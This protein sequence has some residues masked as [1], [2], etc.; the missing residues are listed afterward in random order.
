MAAETR[1]FVS[2]FCVGLF[3]FFFSII[4][5]QVDKT[6]DNKEKLSDKKKMK[7]INAGLIEIKENQYEG[8]PLF[9]NQVH[10]EYDNAILKAD[11]AI[12]YQKKNYFIAKSNTYFSVSDTLQ[13]NARTIEYFGDNKLAK[14]SGNVNLTTK[15]GSLQSNELFYNRGNQTVFFE[16][17]GTLTSKENII[18]GNRGIFYLNEKKTQFN[19]N[20]KVINSEN[21]IL[22]DQA[23]SYNNNQ[24]IEFLGNVSIDSKDFEITSQKTTYYPKQNKVE[25]FSNTTITDKKN[26]T[27]QIKT[28]NGVFFTKTKET[29]LNSRSTVKFGTR[30]I[31]GN[32]LYFNQK[33]EYGKA[34][35]NV[36][37]EDPKINGFIKGQYAEVHKKKDSAYVTKNAYMV[38]SFSKDSLYI[39][40][41]TI[42]AVKNKKA[43]NLV[44]AY[45]K[46]KIF[47]QNLQGEADSIIFNETKGFMSMHKKPI[48][49]FKN[50]QISGNEIIAYTNAKKE[51]L[52]SILVKENAYVVNKVDTIDAENRD[53]NQM[54]GNKLKVFLNLKNEVDSIN[55]VENAQALMFL[56]DEDKLNKSKNRVGI[57]TSFCGTI[58]I[59][60]DGKKIKNFECAVN[61]DSK[62]YPDK[63]LP[64]EERYFDG[65]FWRYDERLKSNKE[66]FKTI[67]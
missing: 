26:K 42:F 6:I 19:N 18:F 52:D 9:T 35:G 2:R 65:F 33:T 49:W 24:M 54:K 25:F 64:E 16:N 53:F 22:A 21:T 56:D 14:A 3:F 7:L 45:H 23:I 31:T 46:A 38:K 37:L 50:S 61:A 62:I 20:V 39:Y 15:E 4:S 41:D 11:S 32:K 34:M 51:L 36:I 30:T 44:K 59:S 28:N 67:N 47:K 17:G 63:D 5:A 8:N 58:T 13:I 43:E 60:F 57:N 48:M 27:N 12:I 55:I 10:F 40:S 66:Y 29:N 1:I